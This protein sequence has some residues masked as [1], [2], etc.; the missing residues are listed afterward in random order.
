MKRGI[1]V[2]NKMEIESL[3]LKINIEKFRGSPLYEKLNSASRSIEN[4]INISISEEELESILDEIGPPVSNDSIL[5]SAYE[6]IISLLQR[7]RS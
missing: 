6:K 2:L 7:M 5:S 4:N 3:V 1:L